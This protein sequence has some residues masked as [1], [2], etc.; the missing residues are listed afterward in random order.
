VGLVLR[1]SAERLRLLT[2]HFRVV[3]VNG[4]RQAGKTT[5]LRML[6]GEREGTLSSLDDPTTLSTVMDDPRTFAEY[7]ALPRI[8]DEVQ[9]G[10]DPLVLAIK[11]AVDRDDRRGQFVLSG[12]TRFLTVATLSESLAGRAVFLEIWPFT[13]AEQRAVPGDLPYLLLSD[14]AAFADAS[15]SPWQR[16]DY[17]ELLTSLVTTVRT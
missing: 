7:G 5:L 10:G 17:L 2:D 11:H 3:V 6:H 15:S 8:V 13:V 14:P 16:R 9:R 12:S 1:A 4:P